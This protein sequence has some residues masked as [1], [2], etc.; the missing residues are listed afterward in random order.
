MSF[1]GGVAAALVALLLYNLLVPGSHSPTTREANASAAQAPASPTP[2]PALSALVYQAI[3]PSFVLIQTQG[4]GANA[5]LEHGLGSGVVV[6]DRGDILTSLHVV[7]DATAWAPE[8]F[9]SLVVSWRGPG[10][11]RL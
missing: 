7:A 1:A 2:S 3:R 6:T 9:A 10:T 8:A 4:T 5:K 11:S